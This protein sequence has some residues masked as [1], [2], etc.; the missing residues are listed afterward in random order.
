[1]SKIS[2]LQRHLCVYLD[3]FC[4]GIFWTR[5]TPPR[6][7]TVVKMAVVLDEEVFHPLNLL[8]KVRKIIRRWN[9]L[10]KQKEHKNMQI[11]SEIS[12]YIHAYMCIALFVNACWSTRGWCRPAYLKWNSNFANIIAKIVVVI[13]LANILQA[14]ALRSSLI[15]RKSSWLI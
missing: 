10:W 4:G 11:L 15:I 8:L 14:E 13:S 6:G 2:I 12:K 9:H 3:N 1:M 5:L 7:E